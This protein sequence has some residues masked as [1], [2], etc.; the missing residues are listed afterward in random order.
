MLFKTL[1]IFLAIGA[2]LGSAV[3]PAFEITE[4]T[5]LTEFLL[6]SP[7]LRSG[8]TFNAGCF[9]YY[10][11]VIKAHADQLDVD[12]AVCEDS[13]ENAFVLIDGSYSYARDELKESVRSN[14][15]SLVLCDAE[16]SNS[17]AFQCLANKGPSSSKDLDDVSDKAADHQAA[18]LE[19]VGSIKKTLSECQLGAQR[20][21]KANHAQ[22]LEEMNKCLDDPEWD[23]PTT[24][25]VF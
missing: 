1:T 16:N 12:F 22:S 2:A 3:P 24:A 17:M 23:Y 21:Y 18:L 4:E 20:K 6:H 5:T 11:P 14:C 25:S 9:D 8:E 10:L 7:A 19:E 13:Y 15:G